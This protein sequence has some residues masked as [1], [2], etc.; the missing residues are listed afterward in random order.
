M[1]IFLTQ[2]Y[3]RYLPFSLPL[4]SYVSRI[5]FY[6]ARS[7]SCPLVPFRHPCDHRTGLLSALDDHVW[8]S[9]KV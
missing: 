2:Q 6:D 3:N 1:R 5:L 8:I 4:V 7:Q 9:L